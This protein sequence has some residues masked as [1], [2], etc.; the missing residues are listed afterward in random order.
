MYIRAQGKLTF[1]ILTLGF[2][3]LGISTLMVKQQNI[4]EHQFDKHHQIWDGKS[5]ANSEDPDQ[6]THDVASDLVCTGYQ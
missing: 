2:F 1:G 4:V 6:T 3:F 5:L